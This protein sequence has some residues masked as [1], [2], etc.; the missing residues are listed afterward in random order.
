M[1]DGDRAAAGEEEATVEA[2]SLPIA[3]GLAIPLAE[4]SFE[5][6]RSSGPGGQN[7]NKV[8]SRVTLLFLVASSPSLDERQRELVLARLRTRVSKAG[9]LRVSA[10]RHRSQA[11]NREEAIGRFTELLRDALAEDPARR[12]TR[13][14]R[15]SRKRRLQGKRQRGE[16]KRLRTSLD[17]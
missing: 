16:L 9:V 17:E 10:Q 4:L 5:T 13:P 2:A 1:S 8:E 15:A 14:T 11:A 6:S 3:S 12:P 7:V